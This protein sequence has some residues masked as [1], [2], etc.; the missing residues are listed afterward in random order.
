MFCFK[1]NTKEFSLE[2]ENFKRNSFS[3]FM[4][5]FLILIPFF[6]LDTQKSVNTQKISSVVVKMR[7]NKSYKVRNWSLFYKPSAGVIISDFGKFS[8]NI[9]PIYYKLT[10]QLKFPLEKIKQIKVIRQ[11]RRDDQIH[12]TLIDGRQFQGPPL[13]R[14]G[15]YQREFYGIEGNTI[16]EGYSAE[17]IV[18]R[19]EFDRAI[20][21]A[22]E[23]GNISAKV[24][25]SN[26]TITSNIK[27]VKFRLYAGKSDTQLVKAE[28]IKVEVK[29]A[30]FEIPIKDIALI[31]YHPKRSLYESFLIVLHSGKKI[32]CF[33]KRGH[34][35]K[36]TTFA[37]NENLDFIS[38]IYYYGIHHV[39]FE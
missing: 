31:S 10:L 30:S 36:G 16:V 39:T 3:I 19:R 8:S 20:F 21:S 18:S 9:L 29:N 12:V 5:I 24:I 35:L 14:S 1:C 15:T 11:K 22:D 34:Y 32:K 17:Y 27:N 33:I 13:D 23:R 7:D 38:E 37:F 28:K 6:C 26:G 2:K 25:K 4:S